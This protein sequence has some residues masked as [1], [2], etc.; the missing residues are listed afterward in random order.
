MEDV[1][2]GVRGVH[3]SFTMM[4]TAPPNPPFPVQGE[5]NA[6]LLDRRG[7]LIEHFPAQLVGA[8]GGTVQAERIA[9]GPRLAQRIARSPWLCTDGQSDREAFDPELGYRAVV[10]KTTTG[11]IFAR[12][13][14]WRI[15]TTVA[16]PNQ[17]RGT[18]T[19]VIAR[20]NAHLLRLQLKVTKR[21]PFGPQTTRTISIAYSRYGEVVTAP[22]PAGCRYWHIDPAGV[23]TFT[24][25][26]DAMAPTLRNGQ[27]IWVDRLAYRRPYPLT[28]V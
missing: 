1:L 16:G 3:M 18:A 15:S 10:V 22:L 25:E 11:G 21:A 13:P 2:R 14:V 23:E 5:A 7:H 24:V 8:G 27:M 17:G 20:S 28:Q 9:A 19:F 6:S 12:R 26:G 4:E